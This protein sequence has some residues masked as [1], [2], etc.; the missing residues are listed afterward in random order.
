M[1]EPITEGCPHHPGIEFPTFLTCPKCEE[2][3]VDKAR[4]DFFIKRRRA[5]I[6]CGI[7]EDDAMTEKH[8]W[9][10]AEIVALIFIICALAAL[11]INATVRSND[12]L[13]KTLDRIE[14]QEAR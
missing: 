5:G 11:L 2:E 6:I 7:M 8:E 3:R 9:S 14:R 1:D 10:L 4:A 12:N 13:D